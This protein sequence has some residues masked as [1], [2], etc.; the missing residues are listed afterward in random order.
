MKETGRKRIAWLLFAV[1]MVT[2]PDLYGKVAQAAVTV[3]AA[4]PFAYCT[5]RGV[6]GSAEVFS[7]AFDISRRY[8]GTV[9]FQR[10][11]RFGPKDYADYIYVPKNMTLIIPE[12]IRLVME[13]VEVWLDGTIQVRGTL[14]VSE[15][16]GIIT[17]NGDITMGKEGKLI[18]RVP[19]IEK[20]GEICLRGSTIRE[21]QPLSASLISRNEIVWKT[22]IA[23]S[24]SFA[25]PDRVPGLGTGLYDVVFTPENQ[26]TYQ[27]VTIPSC[28]QIMVTEKNVDPGSENTDTVVEKPSDKTNT[29]PKEG[30]KKQEA[31]AV[32]GEIRQ[33][34]VII[35]KMVSR[36]STIYTVLSS[37][38]KKR[39][40]FKRAVRTRGGGQAKLR[41]SSVSGK[42][43]YE[44]QYAVR[45]SMKKAKKKYTKKNTITLRGLKKH[46]K[47]YLRVRAYKGKKKKRTRTKWSS[48]ISLAAPV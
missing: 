40:R 38:Q 36:P 15:G 17:G 34:P 48:V 1:M 28:G 33:A 42:S 22:D 35:T 27:S 4:M 21:G 30:T 19:D 26:W 2:A 3:E 32:E 18:R 37:F 16:K 31:T 7:D 14:D 47:Y 44:I 25:E 11:Y 43:G 8:G 12:G 20:N 24:W 46:R 45:K 5:S 41:W 23:G 29:V 13:N 6:Q 9:T 10:D 39:P